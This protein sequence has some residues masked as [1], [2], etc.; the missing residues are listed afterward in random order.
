MMSPDGWLAQRRKVERIEG[1][2]RFRALQMAAAR[3]RMSLWTAQFGNPQM[4]AWAF[5]AGLLW[6][7]R[8][9]G[10]GRHAHSGQTVTRLANYVLLVWQFISRL[11]ATGAAL[12]LGSPAAPPMPAEQPG[13]RSTD[14]G[15]GH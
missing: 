8:P 1:D 10:S 2:V 9:S 15:A 3:H 14:R 11:R 5:V 12:G 7:S 6:A 4:L 13:D